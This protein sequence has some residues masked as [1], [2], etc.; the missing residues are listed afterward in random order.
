MPVT[1]GAVK[2]R[3]PHLLPDAAHRLFLAGLVALLLVVLVAAVCIGAVALSPAAIGTVLADRLTG[4]PEQTLEDSIIWDLR[5]P[6]ALL[7]AVVGAGLAAAGTVWTTSLWAALPA[8]AA[9]QLAVTVTVLNGICTRQL[10]TPSHLQSRVNTT[11]RMIAWGGTP[12]GALIG[13]AVAQ[14]TSV[15]IALLV[16]SVFVAGSAIAAWQSSLRDPAA[17]G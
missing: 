2:A 14:A 17:N 7:A 9:F 8:L 15:R 12:V 5:L 6:R 16:L 11:G 13:G 3:G 1:H 4:S 10:L